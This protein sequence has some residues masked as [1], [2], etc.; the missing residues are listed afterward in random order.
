MF[1]SFA[2]QSID[3]IEPGV[4]DDRGTEV[5]DL[6]HPVSEVTVPGCSVQPGGS[7]EDNEAR[8]NVEIRWTVY[9]PGGTPGTARSAVRYAG[10]VYAIDG[11]PAR[12]PSPTGGLDNVVFRLVDWKG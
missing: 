10:T 3:V 11:E 6:E 1:P 5:P 4:I 12:W 2:T 8:Q 7:T 9:A